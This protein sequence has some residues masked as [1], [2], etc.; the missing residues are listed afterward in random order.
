[1]ALRLTVSEPDPILLGLGLE[2]A[3]ELQCEPVVYVRIADYYEGPYTVTP[4]DTSQILY[5]DGLVMNG[6]VLVY[7][8]EALTDAQIRAAVAEGWS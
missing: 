6:D 1:M 3:A 2:P 5:T 8:I 7:A 4:N